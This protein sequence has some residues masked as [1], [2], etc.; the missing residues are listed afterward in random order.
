MDSDEEKVSVVNKKAEYSFKLIKKDKATQ[1]RLANAE[2]GLFKHGDSP[3]SETNP[4]EPLFKF[5]TNANGVY[6]GMLS[7]AGT[8]DIY[9]LVPPKGYELI[10]E[11]FEITVTNEKPA[12]T[13][14]IVSD[15]R[16]P[17]KV[18]IYKVD[19]NGG[20][21][22]SGAEFAIFDKEDLTTKI[23]DVTETTTPGTYTAS[24]PAAAISYVVIETKAPDGYVL[25]TTPHNIVI[26]QKVQADIVEFEA[27]PLTISND[28]MSGNVEV[29]K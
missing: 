25:D 4:A 13:E 20:K 9:E 15:D 14:V 16:L 17:V 5:K 10:K 23:A 2:F 24:I 21:P 12:A 28:E 19:S 27:E 3:Y 8:Y 11:C 26:N 29:V 22:L 1:D 7:D 18:T 6:T